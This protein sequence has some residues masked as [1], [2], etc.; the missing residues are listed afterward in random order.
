MSLYDLDQCQ[1]IHTM[2]SCN[3]QPRDILCSV[4]MQGGP[5]VYPP[6]PPAATGGAGYP[7][8]NVDDPYP[9]PAPP[10]QGPALYPPPA[11]QGVYPPPP[12][13]HSAG[14]NHR[15]R[16]SGAGP[17]SRAGSGTPLSEDSDSDYD[18]IEHSAENH[19]EGRPK[20]GSESRSQQS[21][22]SVGE[23]EVPPRVYNTRNRLRSSGSR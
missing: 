10:E 16:G 21:N 2:V 15:R 22:P 3:A 4:L 23:Q 5:Q 13:P 12:G 1:C 8:V 11:G 14:S 20:A 17:G 9:P 19:S 7:Q 18:L 6:P